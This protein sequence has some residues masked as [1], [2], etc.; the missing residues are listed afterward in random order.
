MK[1]KISFDFTVQ[2]SKATS[3]SILAKSDGNK[4]FFFVMFDDFVVL[5][6]YITRCPCREIFF[7][8]IVIV[9]FNAPSFSF[10]RA[11][12]GRCRRRFVVVVSALLLTAIFLTIT[13][14]VNCTSNLCLGACLYNSILETVFTRH[15]RSIENILRV[16]TN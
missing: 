16:L 6:R 10:N 2:F 9:P 15:G 12:D 3:S 7:L 14:N 8:C 5:V 4:A 13:S 11:H 1:T